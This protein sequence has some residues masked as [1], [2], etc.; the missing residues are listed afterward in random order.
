MLLFPSAWDLP[1]PALAGRFFTTEP[2]GNPSEGAKELYTEYRSDLDSKVMFYGSEY[3]PGDTSRR[4]L[5]L[6]GIDIPAGSE[7]FK[8]ID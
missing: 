8:K 3:C 6:S 2:P 1:D 7:K 4:S 5:T